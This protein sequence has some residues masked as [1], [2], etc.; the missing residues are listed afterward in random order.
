MT[1]EF[2]GAAYLNMMHDLNLFIWQRVRLPV[3]VPVKTEDICYF[4]LYPIIGGIK[5]NICYFPLHPIIGGIKLNFFHCRPPR[6]HKEYQ[7]GF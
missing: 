1:T 6:L 5:L 2:G 7:E 3:G 4:P